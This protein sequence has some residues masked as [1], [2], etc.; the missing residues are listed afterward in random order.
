MKLKLNSYQIALIV[1]II[2]LSIDIIT[3]FGTIKPIY[4]VSWHHLI[5]I[6]ILLIV[7]FTL[8]YYARKKQEL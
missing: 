6:W 7:P 5:R 8:G 3:D 4:V 1:T 2:I